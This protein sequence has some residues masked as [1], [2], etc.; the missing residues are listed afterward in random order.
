M[1]KGVVCGQK[2]GERTRGPLAVGSI[3]Q[4]CAVCARDPEM[5][6]V[7]F[8]V[9]GPGEWKGLGRKGWGVCF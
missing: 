2:K 5:N 1:C 7:V 9:Q 4:E 3:L 8:C 6:G